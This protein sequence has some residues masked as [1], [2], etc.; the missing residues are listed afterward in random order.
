MKKINEDQI[1]RFRFVEA[2]FC[3]VAEP[4]RD[5]TC[6]TLSILG[7]SLLHFPPLQFLKLVNLTMAI[8]SAYFS[9]NGQNL[10]I[11][12]SIQPLFLLLPC[13]LSF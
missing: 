11:V 10:Y 13:T 8:N 4:E 2:D 12:R 9:S 1:F 3:G 7:K 6:E 5:T